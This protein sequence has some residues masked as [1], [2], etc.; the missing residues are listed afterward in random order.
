[1]M[2]GKTERTGRRSVY[3]HFSV[4]SCTSIGPWLNPHHTRRHR[5][6]GSCSL[7]D[8]VLSIKSA[9]LSRKRGWGTRRKKCGFGYRIGVIGTY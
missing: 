3:S 9:G 4:L 7:R 8:I 2:N 5:N 6:L 1:M